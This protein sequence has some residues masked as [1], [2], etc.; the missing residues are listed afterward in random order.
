MTG[1]NLGTHPPARTPRRGLPRPGEEHRPAPAPVAPVASAPVQAPVAPSVPAAAEAPAAAAAAAAAPA[2]AAPRAARR[3][4]PRPGEEARPAAAA[5]AAAPAP[6]AAAPAAEAPA[7]EAAAPAAAAAPGRRRGLPRS[8]EAA[9]TAAA[10]APAAEAAPAAAAAPAATGGRRGLPRAGAAAAVAA[11]GAEASAVAVAEAPAAPAAPAYTSPPREPVVR[12][13]TER[14]PEP[15]RIGKFTKG[16]WFLIVVIGGFGLLFAAAMAVLFVRWFIS[17]DFMRD[18]MTT[19]PGESHLPEG[20]P[21]GSPAWLGWQ[22]FFNMFLIVL[23]IR[24]GWQVRTQARPPATWVRN[25]EG[26]IKTKGT[27]KRIS[28]NLWSHFAF[29]SLWVTNGVIFIVLLFV[30]GQWMRVVPTSWDVIPNAISAGLQ[31]VSLDWP[32]DNGWVNYNSLQLI[33]YFMTIFIAAPLAVITGA[34]MSGAWPARATRLNKLYPVE[35]ARAI[36]LPVMLYF[37]FFIFIHVV[38]VFATGAL[39]NLN[40]M[41]AAQGSLDGVQYADNWTGFW[42]FFA[43]LVVVIGGVIAARPLVFAPIAGLMG[44]VGR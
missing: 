36:H 31:Y 40:H 11:P 26:L 12:R 5:P 22:H 34:R 44:K 24:S 1:E 6:A 27:P 17:L 33:A 38:L 37:V 14:A 8:G 21:V 13:N 7:A 15:K 3:G 19:Y 18:F 4:L 9:P 2:A 23:I 10:A 43:S 20:A 42:I 28:I 25:N 39:R 29:D 16:Q 30:S 32:T 41:Y 35:W